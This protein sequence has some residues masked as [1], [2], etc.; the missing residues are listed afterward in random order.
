MGLLLNLVNGLR[1][2]GGYLRE[3]RDE[4]RNQNHRDNGNVVLQVG[5]IHK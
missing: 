1:Y 4:Q 5:L 2:R 3:I